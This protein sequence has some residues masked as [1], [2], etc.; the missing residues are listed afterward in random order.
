M[1][2]DILLEVPR[3][4]PEIN[5]SSNILFTQRKELAQTIYSIAYPAKYQAY[6]TGMHQRQRGALKSTRC[7][8]IDHESRIQRVQRPKQW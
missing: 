5:T 4:V 7:V 3:S 2:F 6:V 1:Q 8:R